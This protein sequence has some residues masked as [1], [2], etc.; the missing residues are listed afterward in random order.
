M[1]FLKR[2]FELFPNR[3]GVEKADVKIGQSHEKVTPAAVGLLLVHSADAENLLREKA[4][5]K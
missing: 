3:R 4:G 2:L 1:K 5:K